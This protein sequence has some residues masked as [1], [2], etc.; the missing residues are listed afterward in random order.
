[1]DIHPEQ[2]AGYAAAMHP[3][4]MP[5]SPPRAPAA[6]P[7]EPPPPVVLLPEARSQPSCIAPY[8]PRRFR[9]DPSLP[10]EAVQ[11][12]RNRVLPMASPSCFVVLVLSAPHLAHAKSR[13]ATALAVRLAEANGP[14]VL[15]LETDFARPEIHRL[16]SI[17]APAGAG[18]S[19]QLISRQ[20]GE[21]PPTWRVAR[22]ADTLDLL[23]EGTI[24][25][26]GLPTEQNIRSALVELRTAYDLIVINGPSELSAADTTALDAVVDGL[27]FAAVPGEPQPELWR[28][29]SPK[30]LHTDVMLGE[31]SGGAARRART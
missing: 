29:F 8:E 5:S 22:C 9:P 4:A 10:L 19:Q 15:L 2:P 25:T 11:P 26:L 3:V 6:Y 13:V 16:C 20:R 18:F 24:R 1:V 7:A 14:R 17:A 23:P 21:G 31:S 12:L 28:H 27:V 30:R